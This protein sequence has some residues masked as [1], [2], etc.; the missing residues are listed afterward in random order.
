MSHEEEKRLGLLHDLISTFG[1]RAIFGVTTLTAIIPGTK[2]THER[3]C[4]SSCAR[5]KIFL[6]KP[7]GNKCRQ[8]LR[9]GR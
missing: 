6:L 9:L 4:E 2:I 1:M 7:S 3:D 8:I 5:I